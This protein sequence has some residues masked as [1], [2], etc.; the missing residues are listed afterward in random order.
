[1]ESARKIGVLKRRKYEREGKNGTV[2]F[3]L[4]R[5]AG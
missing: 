2:N 3:V 5:V 1:M 4:K